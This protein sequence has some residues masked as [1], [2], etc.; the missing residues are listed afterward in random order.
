MEVNLNKLSQMFGGK[1]IG[2][3]ETAITGAAGI[4]EAGKGDIT[5]IAHPR[6]ADELV[7]TKA[8][9]ILATK[10][11]EKC[12]L[13]MLIVENPHYIF[14]RIIS[15]FYEK[16]YSP[17]G[18][19]PKTVIAED[20][21]L[22]NDISIYP[23]VTVGDRVKIGDQV[24]IYPGVFVGDGSEIGDN[25]IIYPN[26][27]ILEKV[28]IGKRVIIHS[29]TVI[30]SDG[31]GYVPYKGK[32]HKIPQI[33]EV[34]I[35]DDVEIGSNVS[36]DRAAL[37]KTIIKRGT[38]IDNL[39]QIAHNVVIGED[40]I[41]VGQVGIS[42]STEIGNHVI[43]AGQVG[44]VDHVKIGDNVLVGAGTGVYK[45]IESNK[46]VFGNPFMPYGQFLRI[47]AIITRLPELRKQIIEQEKRIS[48][49]EKQLAKKEQKS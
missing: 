29:G 34:L 41:I 2:D 8:S 25:C 10:P 33:G 32:H 19:H 47:Q 45:D 3:N 14:S 36:I 18:V 35:E 12:A 38:K 15:F 23:F 44:V 22:G 39:V 42:G 16:P 9:A 24:S 6:Y 46:Q 21:Q 11:I 28:S 31:Y 17:K 26:V 7:H 27:T 20:V 37:G 5:F 30:G 43:L 40:T 4:R 49:L 48:Q 1:I 13:S